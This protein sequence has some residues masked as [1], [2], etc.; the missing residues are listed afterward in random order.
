MFHGTYGKYLFNR[1]YKIGS[2]IFKE[3]LTPLNIGIGKYKYGYDYIFFKEK[4]E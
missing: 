3:I 2:L 1:L 4:E